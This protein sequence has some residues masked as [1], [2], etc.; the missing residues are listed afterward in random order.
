MDECSHD[1]VGDGYNSSLNSL[2]YQYALTEYRNG[3]KANDSAC[4]N[5]VS[6]D[7]TLR[8]WNTGATNLQLEAYS[9]YDNMLI[10]DPR[11]GSIDVKEFR[12]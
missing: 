7:A 2:Q 6:T 9:F 4:V 12:G 10:Y 1:V 8:T 5:D 11:N 3:K